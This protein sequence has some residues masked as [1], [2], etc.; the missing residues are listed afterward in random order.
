MPRGSHIM[1]EITSPHS[2]GNRLAR[3]AWGGVQATLFRLSPRPLYRW[4]NWLLRLFGAR[5]DRTAR[6]LPRARIWAPWN[7]RMGAYACIA[8]DVDVYC[9]APISIGDYAVV[10]QYSY[11]CA[12]SH[13]FEDVRHLLTAAPIVIGRR[14]WLAADVFVGPGVNVGEGTLVGARSSVFGDLPAWSVAAGT[15]AKVVRQR[16]LDP[17]DFGEEPDIAPS[18]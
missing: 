5:L 1:P 6:V 12:A 7:L 14:C 4:R 8:D 3:I 15:P 16:R 17:A 18:N 2:R 9:V 11:L 13:D 10:S